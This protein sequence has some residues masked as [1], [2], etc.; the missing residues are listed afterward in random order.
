MWVARPARHHT[1]ALILGTFSQHVRS[2]MHHKTKREALNLPVNNWLR[3]GPQSETGA[4]VQRILI[5]G[6]SGHLKFQEHVVVYRASW[7]VVC[8]RVKANKYAVERKLNQ[9][10]IHTASAQWT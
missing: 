8:R 5:N 1:Y 3:T 6:P 2:A 4:A 9:R 7:Q 10:L